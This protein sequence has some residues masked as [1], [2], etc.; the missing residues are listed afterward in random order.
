MKKEKFGSIMLD[1]K[2]INLD[3]SNISDLEKIESK[4]KEKEE[5]IKKKITPVFNQ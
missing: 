4:L 2:M 1:G 5:E 3:S